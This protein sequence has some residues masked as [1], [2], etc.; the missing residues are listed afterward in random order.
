MAW[1]AEQQEQG[2]VEGVV[3]SDHDG[4]LSG[5]V[6]VVFRDLDGREGVSAGADAGT[7]TGIWTGAGK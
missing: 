6:P 2:V 4:R 1:S 5:R 7:L 3:E